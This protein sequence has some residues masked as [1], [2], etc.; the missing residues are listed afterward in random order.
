MLDVFSVCSQSCQNNILK[1]R[2]MNTCI[3]IP[4][5]LG[6]ALAHL[7]DICI[8]WHL[9]PAMN[10]SDNLPNVPG[11][12][13]IR[14]HQYPGSTSHVLSDPH[15]ISVIRGTEASWALDHSGQHTHTEKT[16]YVSGFFLF[17][18]WKIISWHSADVQTDK[19]NNMTGWQ[20]LNVSRK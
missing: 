17:F 5:S 20:G 15:R 16:Q 12:F 13:H 6:H 10:V 19:N 11:S 9:T 2:D 3:S 4:G 18:A 14:Y 7:T 8:F 1:N